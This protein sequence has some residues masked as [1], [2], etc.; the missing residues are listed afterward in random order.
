MLIHELNQLQ[1]VVCAVHFHVNKWAASLSSAIATSSS[2]WWWRWWPHDCWLRWGGG[3][4]VEFCSSCTRDQRHQEEAL[5]RRNWRNF[6]QA[7]TDRPISRSCRHRGRCHRVGLTGPPWAGRTLNACHFDTGLTVGINKTPPLLWWT[8]DC[9]CLSV[10][11]S[12]PQQCVCAFIFPILS[13]V[14]VNRLHFK[15]VPR[16]A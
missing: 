4:F 1:S 10:V 8:I 7:P 9:P 11:T 12:D 15:K 13:R 16:N 14:A 3:G 5:G 2:R 6:H